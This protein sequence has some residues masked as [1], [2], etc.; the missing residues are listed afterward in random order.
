MFPTMPW[1][2]SD[3]NEAGAGKLQDADAGVQ[4]VIQYQIFDHS[5]TGSSRSGTPTVNNI[6]RR[7]SQTGNSV[8]ATY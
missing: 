8:I 1:R 3:R 2:N 6:P 4:L 7:A 5:A